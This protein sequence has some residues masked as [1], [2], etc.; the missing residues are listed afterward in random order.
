MHSKKKVSTKLYKLSKNAPKI[1]ENTEEILL[2]FI[3]I[4]NDYSSSSLYSVCP[5]NYF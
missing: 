4:N 1:I 2:F 5:E 3:Q